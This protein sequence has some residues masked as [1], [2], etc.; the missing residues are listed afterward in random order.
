MQV[1]TGNSTL[2][3]IFLNKVSK[4][5]KVSNLEALIFD[6]MAALMNLIHAKLPLQ[7]ILENLG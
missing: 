7:C 6:F 5:S 4:A 3:D 1:H 2:P